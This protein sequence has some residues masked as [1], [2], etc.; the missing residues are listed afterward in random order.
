MRN[1]TRIAFFSVFL[2]FS[3]GAATAL[4]YF[5]R[6]YLFKLSERPAG[7]W[8]Y[9]YLS[10][11]ILAGTFGVTIIVSRSAPEYAVVKSFYKV[12]FEKEKD[13]EM[14]PRLQ[15]KLKRFWLNYDT[16]SFFIINRP[17]VYNNQTPLLPPR[18]TADKPNVIII[19]FES[20]SSRLT[21][22]YN[23]ELIGATPNLQSFA[24]ASGSTVF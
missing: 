22:V 7:F 14:L 12:F 21:S 4:V 8:F 9:I 23:Q 17:Y 24:D 13:V 1:Q 5:L 6:K 2:I 10:I 19:F 11:A 3:I 16:D 20:L 15:E 18:F